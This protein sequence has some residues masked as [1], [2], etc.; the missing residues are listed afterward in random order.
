MSDMPPYEACNICIDLS[1]CLYAYKLFVVK[2]FV[3]P[4]I[5]IYIYIYIIA[6]KIW[7]RIC[8]HS[9]V[10]YVDQFHFPLVY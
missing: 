2:L 5:Y 10:P 9:T 3:C 4:Y 7:G 1:V 8:M 6:V